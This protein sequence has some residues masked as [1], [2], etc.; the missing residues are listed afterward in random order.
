M[1][2]GALKG[3]GLYIKNISVVFNKLVI[4]FQK[5]GHGVHMV[6]DGPGDDIPGSDQK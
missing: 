5:A 2:T 3:K 4:K 1:V 6:K